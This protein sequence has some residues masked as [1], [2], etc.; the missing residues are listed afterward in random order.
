MGGQGR[1]SF[2]E[3]WR[4]EGSFKGFEKQGG[5]RGK[6]ANLCPKKGFS[7]LGESRPIIPGKGI[8]VRRGDRKGVLAINSRRK[9]G[10]NP[11]RGKAPLREKG[12]LKLPSYLKPVRGEKIASLREKLSR[13]KGSVAEEKEERT[14]FFLCALNLREAS[15]REVFN[16]KISS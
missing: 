16:C 12:V 11:F 7:S 5:R 14:E 10:P 6:K 4:D 13:R 3:R 15:Y 1:S 8:Y 9:G 2:L